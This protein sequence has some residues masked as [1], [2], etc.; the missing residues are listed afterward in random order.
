MVT[1]FVLYI[2]IRQ[3]FNI[4]IWYLSRRTLRLLLVSR[5]LTINIGTSLRILVL[6]NKLEIDKQT[7]T[8][9]YSSLFKII[10]SELSILQNGRAARQKS[11]LCQIFSNRSIVLLS[12][13]L[14]MLLDLEQ[15]ANVCIKTVSGKLLST[16]YSH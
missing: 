2:Y 16:W 6:Q 1:V 7:V 5:S 8:K 14:C 10:V 4:G 13:E 11:A 12:Q 9:F 15:N 3:M